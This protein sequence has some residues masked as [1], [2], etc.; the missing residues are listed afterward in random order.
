MKRKTVIK[1]HMKCQKCRTKALEIAAT[2]K[3]VSS[4]AIEGKERDQVVVVGDGVDPIKLTS[5]MR[6]KVGHADLISVQEVKPKDEKESKIEVKDQRLWKSD[7]PQ[8][9]Q[10]PQCPQYP[11]VVKYEPVYD[12][13]PG[14]SIM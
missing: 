3:G 4:V 6:K 11:Y 7:W 8:Y 12:P 2:A 9:P 10:Y 14:C 5:L 13:T 1:V